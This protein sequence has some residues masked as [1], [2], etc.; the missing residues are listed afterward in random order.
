MTEAAGLDW[1]IRR[2][3][4]QGWNLVETMGGGGGFVDFDGDGWLDVYLVSYSPSRSP[5]PAGR[6]ATRSSE[7]ITTAPSP[8]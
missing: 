8:T 3:A 7:T 5:A 4:A 2:I 1:G 6:S